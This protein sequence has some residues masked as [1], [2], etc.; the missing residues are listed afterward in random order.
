MPILLKLFHKIGTE[1]TLLNYFYETIVTLITKPHKESMKKEN[2]T[3]ISLM[4]VDAKILN[5]ILVNQ[6]Q[7]YIKDIINHDQV[8]FIP[9]KQ[10]RFNIQNLST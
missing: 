9:A 7:E 6:V 5:K 8:G 1:G 2:F 4:N 10:G 3:P